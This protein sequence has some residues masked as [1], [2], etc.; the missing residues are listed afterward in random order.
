MSQDPVRHLA[1]MI[2]SLNV[3]QLNYLKQLLAEEGGDLA[4]VGAIIPPNLPLKEG[5]AEV[6]F[7]NWP[8]EYWESQA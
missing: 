2:L 8:A 5:A 6:P 1:R 7:E 4:G 3:A